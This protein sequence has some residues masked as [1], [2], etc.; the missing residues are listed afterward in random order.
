M[1]SHAK[2]RELLCQLIDTRN[3]AD[4]FNLTK[5]IRQECKR[6][7]H[8]MQVWGEELRFLAGLAGLKVD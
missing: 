8:G 6:L 5:A 2:L 4:R 7:D 3:D 1:F